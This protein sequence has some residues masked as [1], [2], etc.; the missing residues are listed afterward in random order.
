MAASAPACLPQAL[1]LLPLKDGR[2]YYAALKALTGPLLPPARHSG[3]RAWAR[4]RTPIGAAGRARAGVDR[5]VAAMLADARMGVLGATPAPSP[6]C[7]GG[8]GGPAAGGAAADDAAQSHAVPAMEDG[9]VWA[10]PAP[11]PSTRGSMLPPPPS[12]SASRATA[13][14]TAGSSAAGG[15]AEASAAQNR[16]VSA[17]ADRL[18]CA[19]LDPTPSARGP[20]AAPRNG[21]SAAD[22][23]GVDA[24]SYRSQPRTQ[25]GTTQGAPAVEPTQARPGAATAPAQLL[26][27]PPL[28]PLR[29]P[30]DKKAAVG[31]KAWRAAFIAY[32]RYVHASSLKVRVFSARPQWVTGSKQAAKR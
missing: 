28:P 7:F 31:V 22:I 27:P 1:A 14:Q 2:L 15:A 5:V 18:V 3:D 13:A 11:A 26:P 25:E 32:A 9:L 21:S 16:V 23:G 19:H 20:M 17:S 4:G 24:A 12:P 6:A 30:E 29:G 8:G 10:D